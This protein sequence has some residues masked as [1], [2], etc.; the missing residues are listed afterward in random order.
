MDECIFS[1][2][3]RGED[4]DVDC[5][6][7]TFLEEAILSQSWQGV[8]AAIENRAR[9]DNISKCLKE[10]YDKGFTLLHLAILL[11]EEMRELCQLKRIDKEKS[12]EDP[13]ASPDVVDEL[14]NAISSKDIMTQALQLAKDNIAK[15]NDPN[16]KEKYEIVA[17]KIDKKIDEITPKMTGISQWETKELLQEGHETVEG[18]IKTQKK[19]REEDKRQRLFEERI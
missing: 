17:R 4:G 3:R 18:F 2:V 19:Q 5:G 9:I 12:L 13:H 15:I 7:F 10:R 11:P 6:N 8:Q 14:L 16:M 1:L